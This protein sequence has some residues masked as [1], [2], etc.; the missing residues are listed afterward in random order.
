MLVV[1][2]LADEAVDAP[3]L[4]LDSGP[5]CG[6]PSA[7]VVYGAG[8]ATDPNV[9]ADGGFDRYVPV[10][11]LGSREGIVIELGA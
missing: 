11:T 7:R 6:T 9:G 10:P 4:S 2:N 1:V 5:L 3:L 8:Q